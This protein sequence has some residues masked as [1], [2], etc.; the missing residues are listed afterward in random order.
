MV[1]VLSNFKVLRQENVPRSEYT[2]Q[3]SA[4]LATYYGYN[5]FLLETFLQVNTLK[6]LAFIVVFALYYELFKTFLAVFFNFFLPLIPPAFPQ[7]WSYSH[8]S[9]HFA[10]I[11]PPFPLICS[12]ISS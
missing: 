7:I 4:D 1:R 11:M 2:R 8:V 3:L 5:E 10:S 12:Q 6:N 9:P